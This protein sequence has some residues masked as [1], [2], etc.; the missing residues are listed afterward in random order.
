MNGSL[1]IHLRRREIERSVPTSW[2]LLVALKGNSAAWR[3]Q[4]GRSRPNEMPS[5]H[6]HAFWFKY[7][8]WYAYG[9]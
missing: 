7:S 9:A 5:R 3:R 1:R 4:C 8:D 2:K 6:G